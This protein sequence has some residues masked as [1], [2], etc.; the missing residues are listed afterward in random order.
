MPELPEI[1]TLKTQLSDLIIGLTIQDIEIIKQKLFTGDKRLVIGKKIKGIRRFAKVL[2]IDLSNGLSLAV[3]LKMSGQLIYRIKN[4]E[5]RI[6]DDDDN[7]DPLLITLPNKHTRVIVNFTD[8]SRLFFNDMRMFGWIKL[9][10]QSNFRLPIS[11]YKL[12]QLDNI[13]GK[14]GPDALEK[15]DEKTFISILRGSNKPIKS[16]LMDQEK[17][18]GV[19]NIYSNDALFLSGINPQIKANTLSNNQVI[20][21]FGNL[22]KVLKDGIR[23]GGASSNN[24]R[25]AYGNKG[26]V[27]EH[28]HVYDR[29]GED[30]ER[31]GE[32]IVRIKLGG[33]GTFYCP[34]CQKY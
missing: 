25:D 33:R 5:V 34:K 1:E 22:Q 24:Y 9:V 12:P 32:K 27:Q 13:T 7:I 18:G 29:E 14:L 15:L 11:N 21:L 28:F 19:G 17:I 6:M 20:K 23:W 16:V 4:H 31:C 26:K 3:H 8:G 30:C 2:V 10:E